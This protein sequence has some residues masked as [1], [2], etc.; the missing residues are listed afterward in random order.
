MNIEWIIALCVSVV[1]AVV[2][3]TL[4]A[5]LASRMRLFT[6]IERDMVRLEALVGASSTRISVL[7]SQHSTV[8][9][10]L[11]RIE[12]LLTEHLRMR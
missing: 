1:I 2:G 5:S 10:S 6:K 8:M 12:G 11:S 4:A 9:A 3:W 7:E